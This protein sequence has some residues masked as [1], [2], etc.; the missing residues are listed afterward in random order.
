MVNSTKYFYLSGLISLS[1]FFIFISLFVVMMLHSNKLPQY[2]LK[3]DDFISI[4]IT[5]PKTRKK[6][7]KK[8]VLKK[9]KKVNKKVTKPIV[10]PA[11]SDELSID[12]LFSDV[13]TKTLKI[14][15]HKVKTINTNRLQEISKKISTAQENEVKQIEQI[16][17]QLSQSS[18]TE[19]NEYLAKIQLQVYDSFYPPPNSQGHTVKA[20]IEL[21]ALG[22]VLDFRILTYSDNAA[23]NAECDK[24]KE[25]LM[26]INFPIN[27][28]NRSGSYIINLTAKE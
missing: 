22:K 26:G 16:K 5:Q 9:I 18:A 1:L 25:R 27:P 17:E 11:P 2:A 19:V 8:K 4:T 28:D 14:Q 13:K 6:L 20:I 3:K 12:D 21:D 15:K 23:L 24:I 10:D 7:N